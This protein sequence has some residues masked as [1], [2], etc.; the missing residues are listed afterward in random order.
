MAWDPWADAR[1]AR[2]VDR[3]VYSPG[4]PI[5]DAPFPAPKFHFEFDTKPWQADYSF[6]IRYGYGLQVQNPHTV[7]TIPVL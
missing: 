1:A 7:F 6:L 5:T 3:G 4:V 2:I